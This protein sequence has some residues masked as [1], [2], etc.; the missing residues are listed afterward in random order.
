MPKQPIPF[1]TRP[2]EPSP[3]G[4]TYFVN[5]ADGRRMR[6]R[7]VIEEVSTTP[8][9]VIDMNVSKPRNPSV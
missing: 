3:D 1:P 5:P 4:Y 8:A 2:A 6:I 7:W 9:Q